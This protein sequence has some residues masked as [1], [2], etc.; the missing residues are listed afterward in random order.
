MLNF[1][2]TN[3]FLFKK[4]SCFLIDKTAAF[5][6]KNRRKKGWMCF[7]LYFH[8]FACPSLLNDS[9]QKSLRFFSIAIRSRIFM[10]Y[11]VSNCCETCCSNGCSSCNNE[12]GK[13]IS[14]RLSWKNFLRCLNQPNTSNKCGKDLFLTFKNFFKQK[15]VSRFQRYSFPLYR[16]T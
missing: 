10:L 2:A 15:K 11:C 1:Y 16:V 14:N 7:F 5:P 3:L 9:V 4:F 12:R 13:V 8:R 6:T